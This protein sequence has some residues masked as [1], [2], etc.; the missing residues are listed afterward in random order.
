ME[1]T[2]CRCFVALAEASELTEE[3]IKQINERLRTEG[4]PRHVPDEIIAVPVIPY[5]LTG[6]RMEVPVR[7]VLM[8]AHPDSVASRDAMAT[9]GALDW[10]RNFA[11]ARSSSERPL[12]E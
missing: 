6:K 5:T 4:S 3:A 11:L 12:Q 2:T 1:A 7:K 8:G 10:F 9:P